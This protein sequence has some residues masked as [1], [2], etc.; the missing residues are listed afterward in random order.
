MTK[1]NRLQFLREAA[2]KSCNSVSQSPNEGNCS[3][4][5]GSSNSKK[6]K[7]NEMS[8]HSDEVLTKY[9]KKVEILFLIL[10]FFFKNDSDLDA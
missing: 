2:L 4:H 1:E 7:A 10:A 5:S 6:D 8:K 3:N 9:L